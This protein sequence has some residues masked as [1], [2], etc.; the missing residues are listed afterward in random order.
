MISSQT[1][2]QVDIDISAPEIKEVHSCALAV[3]PAGHTEKIIG[4]TGLIA[5]VNEQV[6]EDNRFYK[7][8]ELRIMFDSVGD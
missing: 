5:V 8:L 1:L 4:N 7:E 3:L 6:A 2:K